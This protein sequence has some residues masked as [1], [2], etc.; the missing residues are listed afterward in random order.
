MAWL[1]A[2]TIVMTHGYNNRDPL[3]NKPFAD[4]RDDTWV[5]Q[6]DHS[7][8]RPGAAGPWREATVEADR[9]PIARYG[10]A[11]FRLGQHLYMFGGDDGGHLKT[12]SGSYLW[13]SFNNDVWRMTL[14][15]NAACKGT[16]CAAA[17][18]TWKRQHTASLDVVNAP[19]AAPP[20]PSPRSLHACA[21]IPRSITELH[22]FDESNA[23]STQLEEMAVCFGGLTANAA[24]PTEGTAYN[25]VIDNG[26]MWLMQPA[27]ARTLTGDGSA[28]AGMSDSEPVRWSLIHGSELGAA[29]P[30]ARHGHA[31]AYFPRVAHVV[32]NDV[33]DRVEE[34]G[35]GV[36]AAAAT[37]QYVEHSVVLYGGSAAHCDVDALLASG[38]T[39]GVDVS[40][41]RRQY[42]VL[43]NKEGETASVTHIVT[44]QFAD[45]WRYVWHERVQEEVSA[46]ESEKSAPWLPW[47][48]WER[49]AF[50]VPTSLRHPP[51]TPPA[52]S[53]VASASAWLTKQW[54]HWRGNSA[55][56]S[57]GVPSPR[58]L[59]GF[60][61]VS[62][63]I[64]MHGGSLC[65]PGCVCYGDTWQL[66]IAPLVVYTHVSKFKLQD[67]FSANSHPSAAAA[68]VVMDAATLLVAWMRRPSP[69]HTP[70]VHIQARQARAN[71]H[72]TGGNDVEA[73]TTG[74]DG[75]NVMQGAARW[76][77]AIAMAPAPVGSLNTPRVD[78]D[79]WDGL[80]E[81]PPR[82]R[83]SVVSEYRPLVARILQQL[84]PQ[85]Q[86]RSAAESPVVPVALMFG[87]EMYMPST[88]YDDTWLWVE[89]QV[90]EEGIPAGESKDGD[91][92]ALL[93]ITFGE[94]S[95]Y[96]WRVPQPVNG[97]VLLLAAIVFV[98]IFTKLWSSHRERCHAVWKKVT[99]RT[100]KRDV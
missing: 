81:P 14:K 78:I 83:S 97:A 30:H 64:L 61:A 93:E 4:W 33:N 24:D 42:N 73:E 2:N 68:A 51:P 99:A 60:A 44:C 52:S 22:S 37:T 94:P 46:H 45:T 86:Q 90:V 31:M 12:T 29:A 49:I 32:G 54:T 28:A 88:Y 36:N 95:R 89:D 23:K 62:H 21:V 100:V 1:D 87:G 74:V 96:H 26:D 3:T 34:V 9:K 11:F 79:N 19:L 70:T 69:P 65:N 47:G 50:P 13:G 10:Q 27:A 71:T 75:G 41:S 43:P 5:L 91:G 8:E 92:A 40:V 77:A 7:I 58:G 76:I 56:G 35:Q 84:Y 55:V 38:Y 57:D 17:E 98:A 59:P 63:G 20:A 66:V 72:T 25:A 18:V 6:S 16:D 85:A 80:V 82:Y 39:E 48:R 15:P 67:K 53:Q